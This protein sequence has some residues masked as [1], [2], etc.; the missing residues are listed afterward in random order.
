VGT[1]YGIESASP[2]EQ[3]A[4]ITRGYAALFGRHRQDRLLG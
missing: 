4:D 2:A 3:L 1:V